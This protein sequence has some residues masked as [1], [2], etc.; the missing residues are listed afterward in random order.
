MPRVPQPL[1]A[2]PWR[3]RRPPAPTG[4]H[5]PGAARPG[6]ARRGMSRMQKSVIAEIGPAVLAVRG[7][8]AERLGG[9]HQ[10]GEV[11]LVLG[12]DRD[13]VELRAW[14]SRPAGP[15]RRSTGR[16]WPTR[17]RRSRSRPGLRPARCAVPTERTSWS[18]QFPPQ[19]VRA[20]MLPG[21]FPSLPGQVAAFSRWRASAPVC[22][23]WACGMNGSL[24]SFVGRSRVTGQARRSRRPRSGL[25]VTRR[26]RPAWLRT[27]RRRRC[28]SSP[29][30]TG[31]CRL[32]DGTLDEPAPDQGLGLPEHGVRSRCGRSGRC[33]RRRE[34]HHRD[35]CYRR[36]G[37]APGEGQ[38]GAGCPRKSHGCSFS[39]IGGSICPRRGASTATRRPPKP[40]ALV[41]N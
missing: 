7:A 26:G 32:T 14:R 30:R 6:S 36:H 22:S 31:T 16:G 28:S 13:I 35:G 39:S 3:R 20:R 21:N 40:G 34:R 17:I 15:C 1:A 10:A 12:P 29:R 25:E 37:Q 23:A 18:P 11:D 33:G 38:P 4:R 27:W 5:W 8:G 24:Q 2:G 19:S 41:P 9:G